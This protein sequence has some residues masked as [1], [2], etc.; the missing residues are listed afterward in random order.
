ML[1]DRIKAG[2]SNLAVLELSCRGTFLK[3]C[4]SLPYCYHIIYYHG[5]S[6]LRSCLSLVGMLRRVTKYCLELHRSLLLSGIRDFNIAHNHPLD[7][8]QT[9]SQTSL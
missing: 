1:R 9:F 5:M 2:Y 7:K 8:L 3:V 6:E 4:D